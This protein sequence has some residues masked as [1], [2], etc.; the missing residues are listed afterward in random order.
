MAVPPNVHPVGARIVRETTAY[1]LE[2]GFVT[3]TAKGVAIAPTSTL[4]APAD[5]GGLALADGLLMAALVA[6]P[7][8]EAKAGKNVN[9]LPTSRKATTRTDSL[10][11]SFL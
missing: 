8:V 9:A 7:L 5:C 4:G 3:V 11:V 6:A 2:D 10:V 1:A